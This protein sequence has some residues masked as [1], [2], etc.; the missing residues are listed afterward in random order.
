MAGSMPDHEGG[1]KAMLADERS[2]RAGSDLL[3]KRGTR[4]RREGG[5][6]RKGEEAA[7][8]RETKERGGCCGEGPERFSE[9]EEEAWPKA[10]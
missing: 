10:G 9:L 7:V 3:S 2:S 8:K 4:V 1:C 6:K 5:G